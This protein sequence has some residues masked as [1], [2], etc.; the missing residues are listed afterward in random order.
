MNK[1]TANEYRT[2]LT[3]FEKFILKNYNIDLDSL[4]QQCKENKFDVY[5]VLSDYSTYLKEEL[6]LHTTTLKQRI[7]TAKNFLETQDIDIS[8]R[9]FKLKIRLPKNIKREKHALDKNDVVKILNGISEIRL[10]TY[11]M[12]LASTAVR[13]VEG[14]S[15]RNMDL[16]LESNPAK[17][18]LKG[19]FTKT[20]TDRS[21]FI[22]QE[23]KEQLI[24]WLDFKYRKR[25]IC[26]KEDGKS[27]TEYRTPVK[28]EDDL[29]FSIRKPYKNTNVLKETYLKRTQAQNNYCN[30]L[31]LFNKTL[32]RIGR[33][34]REY[35]NEKRREITFHSF[36]SFVKSTISDLG[37]SDY[38]EWFIGH[39]GSTYWRKKD[40]EKA[41]IFQK[42]EPYLTIL[43]ITE[44]ERKGAD[45]QTRIE[46][47]EQVNQVYRTREKEREEKER[48]QNEWLIKM[49]KRFNELTAKFDMPRD[50]KT[51][52]LKRLKNQ[53]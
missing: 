43:D 53:K 40:K 9:K 51:G 6:K 16:D 32:D 44:L 25:R 34:K 11:V 29:V 1:Q 12:L 42:L 33:G 3:N 47:L 4:V 28:N 36:R 45:M 19:E 30:M 24:K 17:I 23:L 27:K 48:K 18:I 50:S 39:A 38:S 52:R 13:A 49:E 10:K 20:K 31:P 14:L 5:D 46:E 37:H 26:F 2:R 7:V 22:T 41:E 35:G 15:I 8:D 21:V